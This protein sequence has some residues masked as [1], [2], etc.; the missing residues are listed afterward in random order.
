MGVDLVKLGAS[1]QAEL[2]VAAAEKAALE[3]AVEKLGHLAVR[4]GDCAQHPAQACS[5]VNEHNEK[6]RT[7]L[8]D[9]SE[10]A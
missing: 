8:G 7:I 9:L 1:V 4:L 6:V 10:S 5:C 2:S 3:T